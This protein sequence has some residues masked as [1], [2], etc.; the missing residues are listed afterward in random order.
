MAQLQYP[1]Q[2]TAHKAR[3]KHTYNSSDA[4]LL[5]KANN[6]DIT[7]TGNS[8][9]PVYIVKDFN[10]TLNWSGQFVVPSLKCITCTRSITE[11]WLA[12]FFRFI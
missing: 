8:Q 5:L 10:P 11:E 12:H 6:M 7:H 4:F 3:S 1:G 2:G 9:N